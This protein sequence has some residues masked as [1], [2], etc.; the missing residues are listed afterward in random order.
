MDDKIE[1]VIEKDGIIFICLKLAGKWTLIK[2]EVTPEF[3]G[4]KIVL[5]SEIE[6]GSPITQINM[7]EGVNTAARVCDLYIPDT[8]EKIESHS[9]FS[10]CS[11]IGKLFM[12]KN[13]RSVGTDSFCFSSIEEVH[14]PDSC[15]EV[16]KDCFS[17]TS[18]KKFISTY[19]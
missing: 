18:I 3:K 17:H 1:S 6:D 7:Y 19:L 16:P 2:N 10:T 12:G 14:W 8:I 11:P 13:V 4:K 5:P 15:K 9:F